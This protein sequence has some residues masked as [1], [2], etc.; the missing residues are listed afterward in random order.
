MSFKHVALALTLGT[1]SVT[2]NATLLNWGHGCGGKDEPV[3][4]AEW[5]DTWSGKQLLSSKAGYTHSWTYT[6]NIIDDGFTVG[7]DVV[8]DYELRF[9]LADDHDL[10]Q[11]EYAK[12]FQVDEK[13]NYW[14]VDFGTIGLDGTAK[15]E[16]QLNELGQLTVKLLA[17]SGDF[18]LKGAELIACGIDNIPVPPPV[19]VP[20]P[21]SLALLG[22]GLLGLGVAR[23]NQRKA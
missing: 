1:A 23:R 10:F 8:N 7:E 16:A 17:Y 14:E 11:T 2:A 5:T 21:S 3:C 6:F 12:L 13:T 22:L 4:T 20:E 18:W 15:G 9:S 19:S